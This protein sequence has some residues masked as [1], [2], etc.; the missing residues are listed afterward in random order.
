MRLMQCTT[1]TFFPPLLL[2]F[3]CD[4]FLVTKWLRHLRLGWQLKN[5]KEVPCMLI[6]ASFHLP[7]PLDIECLLRPGPFVTIHGRITHFI[8]VNLDVWTLYKC[9][10]LTQHTADLYSGGPYDVITWMKDKSFLSFF[11][12]K[13]GKINN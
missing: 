7:L 13:W 6:H 4:A 5:V 2:L 12:L 10:C 8:N 11:F 1:S 9:C 3:V